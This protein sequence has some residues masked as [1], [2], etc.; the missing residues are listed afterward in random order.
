[1]DLWTFA[2]HFVRRDP[3]GT[4]RIEN[5]HC[6]REPE[7]TTGNLGIPL[8]KFVIADRPPTTVHIVSAWAGGDFLDR[9]APNENLESAAEPMAT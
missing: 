6:F 2:F 7:L 3:A 9:H 5:V 1:M 4:P 8:P